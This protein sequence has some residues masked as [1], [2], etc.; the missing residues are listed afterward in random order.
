VQ[1]VVR[2]PAHREGGRIRAPDDHRAGRAQVLDN[3][4]VCLGH[5]VAICDHPAIVDRAALVGVDLHRDGNAV[6][7]AER[8]PAMS[9]RIGGIRIGER[10]RIEA[11]HH[12]A[13]RTV[14][15]I[16][17]GEA[18]FD[19]LAARHVPGRDLRREL[20]RLEAPEFAR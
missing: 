9:H 11:L 17:A 3:R 15:R 5:A 19:R 8:G 18:G 1:I 7:R 6:Q 2:V 4:I 10:G 12:R 16:H 13:Q 20:G 14:H